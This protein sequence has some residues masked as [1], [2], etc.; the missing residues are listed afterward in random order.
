MSMRKPNESPAFHAASDVYTGTLGD[1]LC[2]TVPVI[3]HPN[4]WGLSL[5]RTFRLTSAGKTA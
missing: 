3:V 4:P 1:L 5:G 2:P